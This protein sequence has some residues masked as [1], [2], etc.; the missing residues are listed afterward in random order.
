MNEIDTYL[1]MNKICIF[2]TFSKEL[3]NFTNVI[4]LFSKENIILCLSDFDKKEHDVLKKYCEDKLLNYIN[5]SD[6][7][8]KKN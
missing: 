4:K 7:L 8:K 2:L 1:K 3:D 5:S 6:V